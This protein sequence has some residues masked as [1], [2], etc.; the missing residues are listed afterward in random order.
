MAQRPRKIEIQYEMLMPQ[1]ITEGDVLNIR[2]LARQF[3]NEEVTLTKHD[4]IVAARKHYIFVA[5]LKESSGTKIVGLVCLIINH[6]PMSG[7]EGVIEDVIVDKKVR[8]RNIA[9]NLMKQALEFGQDRGIC[10]FYLTS[11]EHRKEAHALY[12]SLEF[13]ARNAR[14]YEIEYK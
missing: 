11:A 8:G 9:R 4:L 2:T 13:K 3:G 6:L 7:P 1:T 5:R 10:I 12:E 14:V